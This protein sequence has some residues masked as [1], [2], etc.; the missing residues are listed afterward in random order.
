MIKIV[1]HTP[2]ARDAHEYTFPETHRITITCQSGLESLVKRESEKIGLT[3]ITGLDRMI[4]G[5][6]D[7]TTI[8]ELLVRSR[9]SNR[10]YINLSEKKITNFDSLHEMCRQIPWEL[11]LSG[12]EQIVVEASATRSELSSEPTIQ[13]VSQSAIFSTLTTPNTTSGIEV[14]ILILIVDNTAK[15]L[16]DITGEPLHKRGY[17]EEAGDAPIKENL[18]AAMIAFSNW[19]YKTPL[20]DPFCGSGTIAIEAAMMARNIAP[21]VNRRFRIESMKFHNRE[22]LTSVRNIARMNAYPSGEYEIY[23]SDIEGEMVEKAKRNAGR[24][25][26]LDD[27]IFSVSDFSSL[28]GK[29]KT[30]VTNPP[31]GKRLEDADIANLYSTLESMIER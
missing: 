18:A 31:Y 9:F 26:V 14:H 8:Y 25:G 16:L 24:A 21:G 3:D 7:L 5:M 27:I 15:I 1:S 20:L 2:R 23:A 13:S 4:T 11:Y 22:E 6:G 30:I 12:K 29:E 28:S 17:R 19:R 10:V